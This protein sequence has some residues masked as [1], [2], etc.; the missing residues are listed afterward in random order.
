MWTGVV[1][2]IY[3]EQPWDERE[4]CPPDTELNRVTHELL[5]RPEHPR[6]QP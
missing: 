3:L 1:G 4:R 5:A 6:V 2:R